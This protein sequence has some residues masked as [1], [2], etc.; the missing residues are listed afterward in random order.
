MIKKNKK[1]TFASVES[2]TGGLFSSEIVSK[3]GASKF[4]KGALVSYS[5][6]IKEKLG[7]NTSQGVVS[8]NVAR[9]MALKGKDYFGVDY[10]FAFTGN[11][12]PNVLENKEV[13]LIFIAINENVFQFNLKNMSR[14]EIRRF[15]VDFAIKKLQEIKEK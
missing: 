6:E 15:A 2:F 11:A 13:G 9:D 3:P 8:E 5:N 14:N 4:F 7:I 1:L 12:G 10:C